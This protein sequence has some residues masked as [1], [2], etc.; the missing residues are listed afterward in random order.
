METPWAVVRP[1]ADQLPA[2]CRN[3]FAVQRW[4]DVSGNDYGITWGSLDAPL[5]EIGAMTANLMDAVPIEKWLPAA[6]NSQTIY[7]WTQNNHWF[8][9]YKIDQPGLTTFRFVLRPHQG[10]YSAAEAARF[11]LETTRPLLVAAAL[12]RQPVTK[13]LLTVSP[14]SIIVET[15]KISDDGEALILRLFNVSD[16]SATLKLHWGS[17]KPVSIW[18]TDLTEKPLKRAAASMQLPGHG[19]LSLRAKLP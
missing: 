11:G 19:V 2:S 5:L 4:V 17:I 9:N 12:P 6:L 1:N 14:S 15:M 18:H 16:T 3:W 8:T 7:S 10:A 13:P